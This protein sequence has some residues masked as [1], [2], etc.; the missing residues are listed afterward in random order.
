MELPD[1]AAAS[2]AGTRGTRVID[3]QFVSTFD[4]GSV[5]GR[6][7]LRS[8]GRLALRRIRS[9]I[10]NDPIF[11]PIVLRATPRG[12][13]RRITGTTSLV[14]EGYPRSG[15][16]YAAAV[17]RHVGGADF[18]IASHVHTPSQVVLAVRRQVPVMLAIRQ[19]VDSVASLIIAA[20]HVPIDLAIREWMDHYGRLWR[21]RGCFVTATFD[22]ITQD[23]GSVIDRMNDRFAVCV[24][25][26]VDDETSRSAVQEL[27]AADHDR[28]HANDERS[29]PWPTESRNEARR[30]LLSRLSDP[31][32][33]ALIDDAND[34]YARYVA[35]AGSSH[36]A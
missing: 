22:Q 29:A 17:L 24:P 12:T 4:P 35:A 14:V 10:G 2:H 13:S 1:A 16:T 8:R 36:S 33:A 15:N 23:F 6:R 18:T 5:F 3:E 19:P 25:S 27:M 26:F 34:L 31:C 11:L 21:H 30:Y 28:F 32:Y 9:V 7:T 20:P